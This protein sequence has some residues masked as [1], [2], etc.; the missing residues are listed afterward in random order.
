MAAARALTPLLLL[1]LAP[2]PA[3]STPRGGGGRRAGGSGAGGEGREEEEEEEAPPRALAQPQN[4]GSPRQLRKGYIAVPRPRARARP[5]S[6]P[7]SPRARS[8]PSM[9]SG[10]RRC[11]AVFFPASRGKRCPGEAAAAAGRA[12]RA[13]RALPGAAACTCAGS[14]LAERPWPDRDWASGRSHGAQVAQKGGE[15]R[16]QEVGAWGESPGPRRGGD[17]GDK[18]TQTKGGESHALCG[19]RPG[20]PGGARRSRTGDGWRLTPAQRGAPRS[21]PAPRTARP[22]EPPGGGRA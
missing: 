7:F 1:L 4:P 14:A 12:L 19:C 16:P 5:P 10:A 3:P 18:A 15:R 6:P 21:A 17:G 13:D 22:P 11:L 20:E 2:A 9:R 8:P